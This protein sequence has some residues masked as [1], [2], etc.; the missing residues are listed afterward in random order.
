MLLWLQTPACSET[1]S[2]KLNTV[3]YTFL[4]VEIIWTEML[5]AEI[6]KKPFS[7]KYKI[8]FIKF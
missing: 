5:Q 6:Y 1:Y 2:V 4:A 8:A 3:L 7:V